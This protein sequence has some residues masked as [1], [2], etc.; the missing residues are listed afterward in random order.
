MSIYAYIVQCDNDHP[1]LDSY[2]DDTQCSGEAL[3]EEYMITL[4]FIST[5]FDPNIYANDFELQLKS[6]EKL[7][8]LKPDESQYV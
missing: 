6:E 3:S 7:I 4:K 2:T 1:E 5:N 8:L